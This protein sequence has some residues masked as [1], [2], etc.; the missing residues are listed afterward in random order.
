M[1]V[2]GCV[3]TFSPDHSQS[4]VVSYIESIVDGHTNAAHLVHGENGV[5]RGA[6]SAPR[7]AHLGGERVR[8]GEGVSERGC[9]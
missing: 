7:M 6:E 4:T 3:C 5:F 1:H 8:Q 9:Q 2:V